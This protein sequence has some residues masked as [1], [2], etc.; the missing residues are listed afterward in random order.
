MQVYVYMCQMFVCAH[1]YYM[2]MYM[3][4]TCIVCVYIC[5][6]MVCLHIYVDSIIELLFSSAQQSSDKSWNVS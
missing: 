4:V 3:F 1:V 5:V 6:C 2:C